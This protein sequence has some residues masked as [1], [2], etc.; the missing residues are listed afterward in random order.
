MKKKRRGRKKK[1]KRKKRKRG[2]KKKKREKKKKSRNKLR[3]LQRKKSMVIINLNQAKL[4]NEEN[5]IETIKMKKNV[6]K[7]MKAFVK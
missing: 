4:M 6:K 5:W 3:N 2:E 7:L 1:E